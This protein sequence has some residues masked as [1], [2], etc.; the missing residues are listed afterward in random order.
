MGQYYHPVNI[1]KREYLNPHRFGDGLKLL[2]FGNSSSGTM[3]A[4]ALLLADGNGRGGG[5]LHTEDESI[6]GRWAG[7]RIVVAGDYADEGRFVDPDD[8]VAFENPVNLYQV[9]ERFTDISYDVL[10]VMCD[11]EYLARAVA[12]NSSFGAGGDD[13]PEWLADLRISEAKEWGKELKGQRCV[14]LG[15]YGCQ[16]VAAGTQGII[17]N[18]RCVRGGQLLCDIAWDNGQ[19]TVREAMYLHDHDVILLGKE[20]SSV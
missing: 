7:D 17:A 1:D 9:T 8:Q 12:R 19:K 3:T 20:N 18:T 6:V 14:S 15:R 10:K 2:E 13:E 4:L 11:D 5:D 16:E